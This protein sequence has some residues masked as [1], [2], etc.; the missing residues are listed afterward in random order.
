MGR[1]Q[2]SFNKKEVQKRKEKR[3]K[4]KAEKRQA[5]KESGSAGSLDDMI[6]YVDEHGNILDAP[7]DPTEKEEIKAEDIQL[8]SSNRKDTEEETE[9]T[10]TVSFYNDAK[11]FGFIKDATSKQDYFV[12][13][14]NCED[15]IAE[16]N[17]VSFEIE[18]GPKGMVAVK[19]KKI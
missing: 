3:R 13:I 1:S 4:E 16:G 17:R 19:V 18:K 5:R 11:G 2:Q 10:G 8:G 15:E 9:K 12:H 7:P 14:N 6:A